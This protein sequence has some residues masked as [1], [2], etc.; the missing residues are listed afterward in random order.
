MKVKWLWLI[1]LI[2]C[3]SPPYIARMRGEI[4]NWDMWMFMLICMIGTIISSQ[5]ENYFDKNK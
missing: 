1:V 3:A 4:V 5:L 2:F